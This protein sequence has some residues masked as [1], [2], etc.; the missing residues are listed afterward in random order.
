MLQYI[1]LSSLLLLVSGLHR[2]ESGFVDPIAAAAHVQGPTAPV[3]VQP[4]DAQEDSL[5]SESEKRSF[6]QLLHS[7]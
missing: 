6:E 4:A 2:V 1:W 5:S 3:A 7:V